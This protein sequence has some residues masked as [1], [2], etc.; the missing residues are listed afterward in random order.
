[1]IDLLDRL[2]KDMFVEASREVTFKQ[3]VVIDSFGDDTT[4]E[5]EVLKMVRVAMRGRID[6][7]SDSITR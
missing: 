7:V 6:H 4:D 5:F 2:A 1:M 3:F